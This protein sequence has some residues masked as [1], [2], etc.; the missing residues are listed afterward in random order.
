MAT[1]IQ[2]R[3]GGRQQLRVIH[4]LLPR[5]FFFTFSGA[6][7]LEQ[8]TSYRDQLMALLAKNTVP[9]ALLARMEKQPGADPMV[10]EIVSGFEATAPADSTLDTLK[11]VRGDV[12][13]MRMSQLSYEWVEEWVRR[14]KVESNLAP[15]SI[16]KRVGALARAV[17]WHHKR[18][19]PKGQTMPA[20]PLRLLPRGYSQYAAAEVPKDGERK[21][22]TVRDRR[23][24]PDEERRVRL[25][26]SGTKRGDR[27]R[28]LPT[29]PE[30]TLLFELILD[31]GLRLREA[32]RLTVDQVDLTRGFCGW[33]ARRARAG[34]ASLEWCR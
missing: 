12:T 32:Y 25:T 27:E 18:T 2:P 15:G 10:V 6:D 31:T 16:R 4:R 13:G 7:A 21:V 28:A 20:N 5:P 22:D 33:R 34:S 17:D 26:L 3:A 11:L 1:S 23:L 8:A 29:D 14:L 30:F 9:H 24:L 19:T